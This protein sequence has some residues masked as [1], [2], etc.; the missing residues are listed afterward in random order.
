MKCE[1]ISKNAHMLYL[2]VLLVSIFVQSTKR[3]AKNKRKLPGEVS[4]GLVGFCHFV[5]V[6]ALLDCLSFI[7]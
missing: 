6:L 7:L 3:F 4:E 1:E 2:V 5:D